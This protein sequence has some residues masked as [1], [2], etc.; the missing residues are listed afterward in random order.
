MP[1]NYN[2]SPEDK[3]ALNVY[4]KLVRAAETLNSKLSNS[5]SRYKLTLSQ[6]GTLDMLYHLGSLNQKEIAQKLFKSG[7]NITMVID[8]LEK[9]NLV[10]REKKLADRRFYK[11]SITEKGKELYEKSF[12]APLKIL[13]EEMNILSGEEKLELQRMLKLIGKK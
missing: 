1:T 13:K 11:V 8:N 5:I 10:V 12:P 4:I 3:D 6:L 9:Q 2:G 7:G